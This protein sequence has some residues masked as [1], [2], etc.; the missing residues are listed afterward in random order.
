M[1]TGYHLILFDNV[2]GMF[3]D[4]NENNDLF[5]YFFNNEDYAR[6]RNFLL[7]SVLF[8]IST[9]CGMVLCMMIDM[10]NQRKN[11]YKIT[12]ADLETESY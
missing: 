11:M 6:E 9:Y 5:I 1:D 12:D 7:L 10:S 8:I 3:S 4:N 2:N